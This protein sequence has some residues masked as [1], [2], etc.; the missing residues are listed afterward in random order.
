[1]SPTILVFLVSWPLVHATDMYENLL[2]VYI[3]Y[4]D[5]IFVK[6][7]IQSVFNI[8][9]WGE[10]NVIDSDT[11]VLKLQTSISC[12]HWLALESLA[13]DFMASS[14]ERYPGLY[15]RNMSSSIDQ[16]VTTL[17]NVYGVGARP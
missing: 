2:I 12:W 9:V 6:D 10:I 14:M 17:R 7:F 3:V 4:M 13:K 11:S 15:I 1:M 16:Y 5:R 8:Q